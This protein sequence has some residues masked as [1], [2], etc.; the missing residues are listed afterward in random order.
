MKFPKIVFL[1]GILSACVDNAAL[2]DKSQVGDNLPRSEQTVDATVDADAKCRQTITA[3][4]Q[5]KKGW[6]D[7]QYNIVAEQMP[8]DV[9]GFSVQHVDDVTPLPEGGLKSFHVNLDEA[10]G[11]VI[12][13]LGYQ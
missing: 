6:K 12:E 4:V 13:E 7:D 5:S 8:G 10:C 11:S 3:Y 1:A 2:A 9:R